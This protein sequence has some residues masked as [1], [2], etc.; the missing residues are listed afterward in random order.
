MRLKR[1]V[2]EILADAAFDG[3]APSPR[4]PTGYATEHPEAEL[5]AWFTARRRAARRQVAR[6]AGRAPG[7][8]RDGRRRRPCPAYHLSRSGSIQERLHPLRRR[9][10][11][12]PLVVSRLPAGMIGQLPTPEWRELFVHGVSIGCPP[13]GDFTEAQDWLF[14][15]DPPGAPARVGL[16]LHDRRVPRALPRAGSLRLD[17]VGNCC[18]L[19]SVSS[20]Q[21]LVTEYNLDC[22][23]FTPR[24]PLEVRAMRRDT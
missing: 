3:G 22:S 8:A 18:R 21:G 17:H 2:L 12:G 24:V 15:R 11:A 16:R 5:Y 13:D 23:T 4:L 20:A 10:G 9:P 1:R 7:R 6:L 19:G 14:R